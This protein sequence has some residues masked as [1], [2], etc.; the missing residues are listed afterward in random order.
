VGL[1]H[2]NVALGTWS[3]GRSCCNILGGL[4]LNGNADREVAMFL[5]RSLTGIAESIG[6]NA[7]ASSI[8]GAFGP[9]HD[10]NETTFCR[11][12]GSVATSRRP[13]VPQTSEMSTKSVRSSIRSPNQEESRWHESFGGLH[14]R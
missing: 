6:L 4:L 13:S 3:R 5:R 12:E 1:H 8:F 10:S 11:P 7:C 9:D 14:L 2:P